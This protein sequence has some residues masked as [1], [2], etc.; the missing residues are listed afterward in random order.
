MFP[1][2]LEG[3][4]ASC[5][6]PSIHDL[7]LYKFNRSL[8]QTAYQ[9]HTRICFAEAQFSSQNTS[10]THQ[11]APFPLHTIFFIARQKLALSLPTTIQQNPHSAPASFE[12]VSFNATGAAQPLP[13][14]LG[15]L[16][17]YLQRPSQQLHR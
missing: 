8:P 6:V 3:G 4:N 5:G 14:E 2:G 13:K 7:P 10:N 9:S 17:L 15:P 12:L 16:P 11:F 1:R